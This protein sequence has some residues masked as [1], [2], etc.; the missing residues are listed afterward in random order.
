MMNSKDDQFQ[1]NKQSEMKIDKKKIRLDKKET[2][3]ALKQKAKELAIAKN[4]IKKEVKGEL[5]Q[6]KSEYETLAKNRKKQSFFKRLMGIRVKLIGALLV[7][8]AFIIILGI[9]AY[10]KA[11][12][13]LVEGYK[14]SAY[15][16]VKTTGNYFNAIMNSIELRLSQLKSH[17]GILKYY[18]GSYKG[19][20][21]QDMLAYND[22]KKYVETTAFSDKL[23]TNLAIVCSYGK[24]I[25]TTATIQGKEFV[26]E[27]EKTEEGAMIKG[28][29][30]RFVWTGRHSF[31]DENK[32]LLTGQ[33]DKPYA[34]SI[35]SGYYGS[36]FKFLGYVIADVN[37]DEVMKEL[38]NLELGDDS[39]FAVISSDGYEFNNREDGNTYIAN[40]EFYKNMV[41]SENTSG[42]DDIQIDGEDYLFVYSTIGEHGL[43]VSGLVPYKFLTSNA[44]SIM[45]ST[46]II[47][48]I[49]IICSIIIATMLSTSIGRIIL[50]ITTNLKKAA[51]G[52]LSVNIKCKRHDE[53]GT[54]TDSAN[55]MIQNMKGLI[56]KTL[57][58]KESMNES[59]QQV[60]LI[61]E[62]L[63]VA[64]KNISASIEEIRKGIVQQAEDSEQC[65]KT[66]DELSKKVF[67][68]SENTEAIGGL[69][70]SSKL[71]VNEGIVSI[72][73]LNDK[74]T[75]TTNITKTIITDITQLAIES[76]SIGQI[77]NVMNEIAEQTNLLSLNASIE[78][79]RAGDAGRG[80]AVVADEIRKLA[81]QSVKASSE[82]A[83][84]IDS[85]KVKTE[86]T[87]GTAK[88]SE[89]IVASQSVALEKTIEVFNKINSSVEDMVNRLSIIAGG[90]H[91]IGEAESQTLSAIESIS[92]VSEETAASSEEV[93][94]AATRQVNAV[95][96]LNDATTILNEKAKE[97]DAALS[98]FKI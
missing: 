87:V 1:E 22:I 53:F 57:D 76:S 8:I 27:Y 83:T 82:I 50:R 25:C 75:E 34:F 37:Y 21:V 68:V 81:E 77:I 10:D 23:I 39:I 32:T 7:P 89:E 93:E 49:A 29:N 64:T 65:L 5:S 45:V 94:N 2:K 84:I 15:T 14:D 90:I 98:I 55:N 51:E 24:P 20:E 44:D 30:G 91:D 52:D 41:N 11:S 4:Q 96:K 3:K 6:T 54:L 42:Y 43:I 33:M 63:M 19:D 9:H 47:V 61:A 95:E 67:V 85:I 88:K 69:A 92:A 48:V 12:D 86:K 31:F 18:N 70:D 66:S 26:T 73:T 38:K 28:L 13:A 36:N 58:V 60:M 72:D 71:I 80:F 16:S 97:L 56:V 40:T 17:D 79:A 46:I 78:A 59:S 35:S 62:E 74:A